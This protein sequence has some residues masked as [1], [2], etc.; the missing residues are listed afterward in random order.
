MAFLEYLSCALG[1]YHH[2][3]NFTRS[4]VDLVSLTGSAVSHKMLIT[5]KRPT[6]NV[7]LR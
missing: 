7:A 1:Q 6:T 5:S 4:G 3:S 2:L